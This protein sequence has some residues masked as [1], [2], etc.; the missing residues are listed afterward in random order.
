[1]RSIAFCRDG[2]L[3]LCESVYDRAERKRYPVLLP[4]AEMEERHP[5]IFLSLLDAPLELDEGID[6]RETLLNLAPWAHEVGAISSCRFDRFLDEVRK[7]L[8]A[9][10]FDDLETVGFVYK[11]GFSVEPEFD[12]LEDMFVRIPG[13]RFYEMRDLVPRITDK[14]RVGGRWDCSGYRKGTE[15]FFSHDDNGYA[16]D[17]APL[18]RWHHLKLKVVDH[19]WFNDGTFDSDFL[20]HKGGLLA[21]DSPS[22]ENVLSPKGRIWARRVKVEAPTPTLRS[23]ILKCLIW[24]IGFHG[25]P[26]ETAEVAATIEDRADGIEEDQTLRASALGADGEVDPEAL[27][28]IDAEIEAELAEKEAREAAEA[29]AN[30]FDDKD[31]RTLDLVRALMAEDPGLVRVPDGLPGGTP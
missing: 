27:A 20:T 23:L 10:H 5:G 14:V 1:M 19:Y 15:D 24:E 26:E 28:R 12:D 7:P 21:W 18:S 11:Q 31:R 8:A 4:L 25:S 13:S 30:P 29:R 3:R 16:L 2:V 6:V 17:L 9:D 22:V